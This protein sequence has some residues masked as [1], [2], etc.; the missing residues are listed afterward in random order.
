MADSR[1]CQSCGAALLNSGKQ[2]RVICAY[3]GAVNDLDKTTVQDDSLICSKCFHENSPDAKH[4]SN[5][6]ADLFIECPRCNTMNAADANHCMK[7][8]VNLAVE[9]AKRREEQVQQTIQ[10]EVRKEKAQR[11]NKKWIGCAI[12][13]AI[14]AIFL[15]ITIFV[16]NRIGEGIV[17]KTYQ[18][19]RQ[20]DTAM[21]ILEEQDQTATAEAYPYK[22]TSEDG[23]L[24]V[25]F[26][27][28]INDNVSGKV[29]L[30]SR[31]FNHTG[32]RC[33]F[34]EAIIRKAVDDQGR[35]Y[36]NM[37]NNNRQVHYLE[38]GE[39]I[40][41]TN[42]LEPLL[43]ADVKTLTL[44]YDEVCGYSGITIKIDLSSSLIE[45]Q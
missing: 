44:T 45:I 43:A 21:A 13:I 11:I 36:L 16:F 20:T 15:C 3:C 29:M 33:G 2:T 19:N 35:T 39:S 26:S 4:C 41:D 12:V 5:C 28:K 9:T 37:F 22:W 24:V 14:L 17:E 40:S 6:G 1:R 31:V 7:C 8:G 25:V 10:E 32:A 18:V 30:G 27:R 23:K 38:D 34:N 42:Y